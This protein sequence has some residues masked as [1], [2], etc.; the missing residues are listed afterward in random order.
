M[1]KYDGEIRVNTTI[2]TKEAEQKLLNLQNHMLKTSQKID[3]IAK[4]M[5]ELKNA[6]VENTTEW[7]KLQQRMDEAKA[8]VQSLKDKVKEMESTD[9]PTEEYTEIQ[10][11]LQTAEKEFDGLLAKQ[12]KM[13]AL[14]QDK[15]NAWKSLQYDMEQLGNAIEADR[16]DLQNLIDEGKAFTAQK[17]TDAYKQVKKDLAAARKEVREL[18]A[19]AEGMTATFESDKTT[20][21]DR[22]SSDLKVL[23]GELELTKLKAQEA[24]NELKNIEDS[25]EQGSG[26]TQKSIQGIR[27]SFAG[28][29]SAIDK[30][31]GGF[32]KVGSAVKSAFGKINSHVKKSSGLLKTMGSRM[33][34][35]LLSM[36]VFNWISKGWN[37]LISDM[38]EGFQ[39]L[40]KY[41]SEYN[42]SISSLKSANAELK[43]NLASAFAPIIQM[44]IPYLV[45]LIDW[46][47]TAANAI[48]KFFAALQGKSTYT[49][50]VKQNI[51]YAASLKD[52]GDSAK[53]SAGALASFD[54]LDVLNKDDNSGSGS[55]GGESTGA[56]AF[57]EESTGAVLDWVQA[58][59]DA[60]SAGDW[61]AVASVLATQLDS[62]IASIDW[63]G[64]GQKIGYYL[65]N[66][67]T[68]LATFIQ[69][70]D[71]YGLG[72]DLGTMLNNIIYGV[73]WSNLGVILGAKF[74]MLIDGLGG[75]FA[76]ID[77]ASLGKALAD[78][79]MGLWNT[80]DWVQAAKTLSDGII[81]AL[82]SLS[83]AIKNVDWQKLG[84]DIAA[85]IANIDWT[86]IIVALSD[87]I[88]AALGGLAALLWGLIEDAWNS[89]VD[90]W[91]DVAY[92]DG[93]FT[94]EGLLL[95]IGEKLKSIGTWIKEHIFQPFINGFKEAF[96][97]N[98]PSTVMKEMGGYI[99]DG[100]KIGLSGIWEKVR[101]IISKFKENVKT[102]FSN[103]KTNTV[104]IFTSM[105]N[106][107][108]DIFTGLWSSVKN[109]INSM[110]GGV[111]RMANGVI[112]GING[113]I[114]A[115]NKLSFTI[116]NWIPDWGGKS[117]GLNLST[118]GN[119]S[120]PRL[121]HGG[122]T[123]GSTLANIGE[124]G[125]EAVLPLENNTGWMDDLADKLAA[126]MPNYSTPTQIVMTLDGKEFARGELPYF[127]AESARIGVVLNPT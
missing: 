86:G 26:K 116:P 109:I 15:G 35:M 5:E 3:S 118:I 29:I 71:W 90:W 70:F 74:I 87:G 88:G 10:N 126:R 117:F 127:N 89:V 30:T 16:V 73:D 108:K 120:I 37:T 44:A 84:N 14:G 94:M 75:L 12:E 107:V 124:A 34:S 98:S 82:N 99:I 18:K 9:L 53:K 125:R 83:T 32:S 45:K 85:F 43:N 62:V 122:I 21:I 60:I 51:N 121:A 48:A 59:K 111:E 11:H 17:G 119:I 92:D 41:S 4:K 40:A 52:V 33:K 54:D 72:A 114:N 31:R 81:G 13:Q 101:S 80:I 58:L 97:I 50:A 77:W 65:N 113:M 6:K 123:T 56:A 22:M 91:H 23:E 68:F 28:V 112:N 67:L 63:A 61:A 47:N 20:G 100:L 104:S 64:L 55:T 57:E 96:G 103:I 27:A 102:A 49:K 2:K 76:T 24:A 95:G 78:G 38:K 110:L 66:A 7:K 42:K 1:A 36:L 93:G 8:R 115:L 69:S 106:R 46:L 19:E 105:K 39:N 25:G 79:F